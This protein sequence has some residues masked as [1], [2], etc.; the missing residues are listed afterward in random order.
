MATREKDVV[1]IDRFFARPQEHYD[2]GGT[3]LIVVA[4]LSGTEK[5]ISK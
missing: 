4:K 5:A 3:N 2:L 1:E